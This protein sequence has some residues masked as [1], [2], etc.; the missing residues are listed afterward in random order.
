M[1]IPTVPV[2]MTESKGW[3]QAHR[4]PGLQWFEKFTKTWDSGEMKSRPRTEWM[5]EDSLM[6]KPNGERF[7]GQ[8]AWDAG[9]EMF[10]VFAAHKHEPS[11]FA[12]W[13]TANGWEV[14]AKGTMFVDLI[15]PGEKKFKDLEGREWDAASPG[16]FNFEFVR[17][18]GALHDGIKCSRMESYSD[19]AAI[20]VEMVK[21][22]M[23]KPEQLMA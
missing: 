10:A 20:M 6:Q 1:S 14:L 19:S 18:E 5:T 15:V 9:L 8:Q 3:E 22:G 16:M 23:V 2:F 17:V 12:V 21:R 13:E 4:H 7:R 11:F